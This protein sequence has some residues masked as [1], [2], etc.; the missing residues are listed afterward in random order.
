MLAANNLRGGEYTISGQLLTLVGQIA[1]HGTQYS[2]ASDGQTLVV[3]SEALLTKGSMRR[4]RLLNSTVQTSGACW[5]SLFP[6]SS[7]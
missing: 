5:L 6:A 3:D 4:A 2:L 1:Y 7:S